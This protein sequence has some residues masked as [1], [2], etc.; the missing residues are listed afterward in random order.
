MIAIAAVPS[1]VLGL[2]GNRP[3]P[4]AVRVF[5]IPPALRSRGRKLPVHEDPDVRGA[6]HPGPSDPSKGHLDRINPQRFPAQPGHIAEVKRH[7]IGAGSRRDHHNRRRRICRGRDR[8]RRGRRGGWLVQP[9]LERLPELGRGEAGR[10]AAG[11]SGR[12]GL[13]ADHG[14]REA[15]DQIGGRVRAGG[16]IALAALHAQRLDRAIRRL[17]DPVRLVERNIRP[18]RLHR[19][20]PIVHARATRDQDRH[21]QRNDSQRDL[22]RHPSCLAFRDRVWEDDRDE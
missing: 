15:H 8:G 19:E 9:I 18:E 1:P 7:P 5:R 16:G 17:L 20:R 2:V 22:H 11:G 10:G 21:S 12:A 6:R 13:Q 14:A 4:V 3:R